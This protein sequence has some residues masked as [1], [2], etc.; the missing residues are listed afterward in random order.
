MARSGLVKM[1]VPYSMAAS[2]HFQI[3]A[4]IARIAAIQNRDRGA[5]MVRRVEMFRTLAVMCCFSAALVYPPQ[6]WAAEGFDLA[7]ADWSVTSPHNLAT[8]PPADDMGSAVFA[9]VEKL[10]PKQTQ[11]Y[12]DLCSSHPWEFADLHRSGTLS[13]V[14]GLSDGRFC[15]Q[16]LIIDKTTSGFREYPSSSLSSS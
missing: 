7:T 1:R 8:N 16:N 13:L 5:R 3:S 4:N 12:T 2:R 9:L 11:V 6:L 10:D 14:V 15:G